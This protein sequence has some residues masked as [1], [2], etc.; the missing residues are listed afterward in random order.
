MNPNS[1]AHLY[2]VT[3]SY[4][5]EAKC[6]EFESEESATPTSSI[7]TTNNSISQY[8]HS[9]SQSPTGHDYI[10]VGAVVGS[11]GA[12]GQ[13]GGAKKRGCFPKNAT[14]KLKH[15]L[16]QHVAVCIARVFVG[17]TTAHALLGLTEIITSSLSL[18]LP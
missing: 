10:D 12:A 1:T 6:E 13:S 16:F 4:V 15:W 7:L 8:S 14:N 18:P 3:N 11:G 9:S 5:S 2:Y 17:K